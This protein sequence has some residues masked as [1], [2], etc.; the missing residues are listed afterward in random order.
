MYT[1]CTRPGTQREGTD[2]YDPTRA[3]EKATGRAEGGPGVDGDVRE[4]QEKPRSRPD[5]LRWV[6]GGTP[7]SRRRRGCGVSMPVSWGPSVADTHLHEAVAL[8]DEAAPGDL[9]ELLT[10]VRDAGGL[11]DGGLVMLEEGQCH[12]EDDLGPLAEQAVPDT[13][14][15]LRRERRVSARP[16]RRPQAQLGALTSTGRTSTNRQMNQRDA[17][18]V[19]STPWL[20][21][22]A[23]TAGSFVRTS[24]P[25]TSWSVF[26]PS[27]EG[28]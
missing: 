25:S 17:T 22:S 3:G 28:L 9:L 6:P 24:S 2:R 12:P 16:C 7:Y 13:Q 26:R 5:G 15:R 14:H 4:A 23:A 19:H 11:Q 18:R 21:I 27:I 10:E 8:S 20:C 1:A